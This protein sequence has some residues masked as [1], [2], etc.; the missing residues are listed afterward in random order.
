M[1]LFSNVSQ[2]ISN[3]QTNQLK[4]N[5]AQFLRRSKNFIIISAN[6]NNTNMIMLKC[7]SFYF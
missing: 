2:L 7:F 1:Y 3:M 5:Y 6:I 4:N